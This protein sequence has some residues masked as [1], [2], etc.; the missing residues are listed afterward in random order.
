M[1]KKT[2]DAIIIGGG[3]IGAAVAYYLAR[4]GVRSVVLEAGE[5]AA[6]SSGACD[7]HIFL[8]SKKPGEHL[9][10]ALAGRNCFEQ[11]AGELDADIEY[12]SAGGMV[13]VE[14]EEEHRAMVRRLEVQTR[15]GLRVSLLDAETARRLEPCLAP[16]IRAA[17][18]SPMD[19]QVN[20]IALT[21]A[22]ARGAVNLG[23][24][25]LTASP[26]VAIESTG[27]RVVAVRTSGDRIAGGVVVNAAGAHAA[28]V[29]KMVGLRI[30]VFPRRGQ[31]LVTESTP[32]FLH[33]SLL[34]AGYLAAKFH[35]GEPASPVH[36]LSLEQTA[37]GN[38]L[39]GSTREFV[40]FD[41]RTTIEGVLGIARRAVR[42]VPCLESMAVIRSFAGLRPSTPDGLPIL[43]PVSDLEN[44]IMA[45]GHEG[46]GIALAPLTGQLIAASICRE[47]T[48][49]SLN[50]F[51]LERFVTP[52]GGKDDGA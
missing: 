23:V 34:S 17:V 10:M 38:V 32:R 40:G 7:G 41:R 3:V 14:N 46:D 49:F 28:A 50:A 36:G 30:P 16:D 44:F 22:L 29:G 35:S 15:E 47:Q 19:A 6:G 8:Q 2:A 26:V 37:S 43:G 42:W 1:L 13:I 18:F 45:A 51:R 25:I 4:R 31:L 20:P 12:R 24:R 5:L 39:I 11:L 33:H 21:L 9:K 27:N 48:D 52:A